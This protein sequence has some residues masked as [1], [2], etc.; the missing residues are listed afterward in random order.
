M[1]PATLGDPELIENF[2]KLVEQ[3]YLTVE[4]NYF[5]TIFCAS[6][7]KMNLKASIQGLP[8]SYPRLV[9][10]LDTLNYFAAVQALWEFA[11]HGTGTLDSF[12]ARHGHHSR[13]ELDLRVPRWREDPSFVQEL[14]KK[15]V[16]ADNPERSNQR[17][18]QQWA[19]EQDRARHLLRPWRRSTFEKALAGLRE[20]LWLREQM[21]DLS[22]Q[23][24]AV[25]RR[26]VLEIGRR[27]AA[28]RRLDTPDDIF[29]LTFREIYLALEL[30]Q[31]DVV[32]RRREHERMYR[33]FHPPN[34]VGR[35]FSARPV[36]HAGMRLTGIGCSAGVASGPVQVVTRLE[37]ASSFRQGA[38]LVCPYSDPGWTPL[39]SIAGAV[40]TET[41]G[42]LSHAAVICREYGIP[43]VLNVPGATRILRDGKTVRV[44][45][46]NGHVDPC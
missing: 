41:G 27:A 9:G 30:S 2:T 42:L 28:R 5:R 6:I 26:F 18:R 39:L 11:N 14:A 16:G 22:T 36:A 43:A 35:T 4:E 3:V 13:R 10:G 1:D 37:D 32:Q 31:Q 23:V 33:N 15:L 40:V 46:E 21:R 20:F 34:E 24:Y 17:Q 25:I 12:M 19:E 45:G 29:Y 44:D 7:A 38:V 8:V